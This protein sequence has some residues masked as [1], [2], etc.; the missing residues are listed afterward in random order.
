MIKRIEFTLNLSD[1]REAQI[2]RALSPSLRH[3]R[4]GAVIRQALDTY[5]MPK[6]ELSLP[7]PLMTIPLEEKRYE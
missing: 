5:L 1:P 3:R 7:Q 2:Y 4:A 6:R